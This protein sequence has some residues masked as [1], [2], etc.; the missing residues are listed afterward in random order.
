MSRFLSAGCVEILFPI[1][2]NQLEQ[3]I[4]QSMH[5]LTDLPF[6]SSPF[7][8]C[9]KYFSTS[10]I[11]ADKPKA[12]FVVKIETRYLKTKKTPPKTMAQFLQKSILIK[13]LA[14][15]VPIWSLVSGC[16]WSVATA[17][18]G[19]TCHTWIIVS[20]YLR[21]KQRKA[22]SRDGDFLKMLRTKPVGFHSFVVFAPFAI[23]IIICAQ[24]MR[25]LW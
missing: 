7:F 4:V 22:K 2:I 6:L 3:D 18:S 13:F 16:C 17:T 24:M 12:E 20:F 1:H 14:L 23:L 9:R 25:D 8:L 11:S 5:I 21:C 19:N 10:V 15:I